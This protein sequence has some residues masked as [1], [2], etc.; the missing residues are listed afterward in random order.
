M[1]NLFSGWHVLLI[2]AVVLLLF[3]APK[4]PALARAIGQSMNILKSETSKKSEGPAAAETTTA[5]PT[6]GTVTTTAT[7]TTG[8]ASPSSKTPS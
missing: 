2:L 8:V 1:G 5:E 7:T 6:A 3:G 4:L